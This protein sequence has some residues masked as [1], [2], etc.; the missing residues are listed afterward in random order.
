MG[1][2]DQ[3]APAFRHLYSEARRIR[4]TMIRA[5]TD[6]RRAIVE[7]S[8]PS[9]RGWRAAFVMMTQSFH[10]AC[11]GLHPERIATRNSQHAYGLPV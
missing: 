1:V 6:K 9:T 11:A 8:V 7:S 4:G 3:N 5:V 10:C 2:K